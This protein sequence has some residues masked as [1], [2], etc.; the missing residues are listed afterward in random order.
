MRL[1][2]VDVDEL[3]GGG[4]LGDVGLERQFGR[5]SVELERT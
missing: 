3:A 1:T 4:D 2:I 5:F